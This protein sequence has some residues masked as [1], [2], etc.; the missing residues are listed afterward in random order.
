[1]IDLYS[2]L[3]EAKNKDD[4]NLLFYQKLVEKTIEE[5][6]KKR[7]ISPALVDGLK[8]LLNSLLLIIKKK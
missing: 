5:E 8:D 1:M 4:I 3:D 6:A 7:N 2:I